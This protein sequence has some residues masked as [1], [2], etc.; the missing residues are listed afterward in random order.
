M[1]VDSLNACTRIDVIAVRNSILLK[2]E[3]PV[4]IA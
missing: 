2:S 4:H 3:H 1:I